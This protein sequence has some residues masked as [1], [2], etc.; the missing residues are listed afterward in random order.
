M[1]AWKRKKLNA[2]SEHDSLHEVE[3]QCCAIMNA[4]LAIGELRAL[5]ACSDVITLKDCNE[6]VEATKRVM[7]KA[8]AAH[9]KYERTTH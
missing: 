2:M 7:D 6:I 3:K 1:R 4:V 5:R 9:V 8:K